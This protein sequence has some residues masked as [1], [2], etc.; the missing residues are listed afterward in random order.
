ML[1]KGLCD[2]FTYTYPAEAPA[3]FKCREYGLV[4]FDYLMPRMDGFEFYTR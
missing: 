3:R 4:L 2:A 1:L